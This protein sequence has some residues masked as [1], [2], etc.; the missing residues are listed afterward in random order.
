M[1]L[2][3]IDEMTGAHQLYVDAWPLCERVHLMSADGPGCVK[4][5][6]SNVRVESLSRLR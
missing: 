3:R 4:T 2:P 1:A 6:T 5:P